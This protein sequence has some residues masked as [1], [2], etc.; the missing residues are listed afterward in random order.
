[1][2]VQSAEAR[3]FILGALPDEVL[4]WFK[5]GQILDSQGV[6]VHEYLLF[7][8]CQSVGVKLREGRFE[9]KAILPASQSFS[10]D[11]GIQGTTEQWIKWS[12]AS[13]GLP[14]IDP[15]LHQSG[16]WL[17]VYKDRFLRKLSAD[18][19]IL[20]EVSARPGALPGSGCNIE[21]TRIELEANPRYWFSLG[22]EAFGPS[23]VAAK[24]LREAIHLF[25]QEHG[26]VPG[27]SLRE[28]DSLSYPAWLAKVTNK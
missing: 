18:R 11:L 2:M 15:A 14:A 9:I 5:G 3:W 19:G 8:G 7:P 6:Q 21:L 20:E 27:I 1:M 23:A 16:L 26:R 10:L 12:F 17:K 28:G 22:F 13:E 25:F 4:R 24:I